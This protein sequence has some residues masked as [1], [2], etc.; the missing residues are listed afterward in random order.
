MGNNIT[1]ESKIAS[2]NDALKQVFLDMKKFMENK[3]NDLVNQCRDKILKY[4]MTIK[5]T[6]EFQK[7]DNLMF[8]MFIEYSKMTYKGI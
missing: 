4:A 6:E 7:I 5:G 3:L 8:E 1:I 2:L